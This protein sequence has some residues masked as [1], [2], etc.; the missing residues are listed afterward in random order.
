[1]VSATEVISDGAEGII[2]ENVLKGYAEYY[3]AD[4]SEKVV[5]GMTENGLKSKYN[6]GTRPV[7]HLMTPCVLH[8]LLVEPVTDG[9]HGPPRRNAGMPSGQRER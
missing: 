5:R 3:S 4:L 1:M 8:T 9:C 2:L 6:G 7:G